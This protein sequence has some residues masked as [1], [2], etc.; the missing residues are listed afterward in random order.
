MVIQV[1]S[2]YSC[3]YKAPVLTQHRE[4]Y[5]LINLYAAV[6]KRAH[7]LPITSPIKAQRVRGAVIM[8]SHIVCKNL[9]VCCFHGK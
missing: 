3:L 9:S 1:I 4:I 2:P 7:R 5:D 6:E 8:Q